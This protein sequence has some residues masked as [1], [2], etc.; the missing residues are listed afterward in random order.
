MRQRRPSSPSASSSVSPPTSPST[1]PR[2]T[3]T[4]IRSRSS[5]DSSEPAVIGGIGKLLRL[6]L[7]A[8]VLALIVPYIHGFLFGST[9]VGIDGG[10][11]AKAG[12]NVSV[13]GPKAVVKGA[14]GVLEQVTEQV[15]MSNL[16]HDDYL[17]STAKHA[18]QVSNASPTAV[19]AKPLPQKQQAQ[20]APRPKP[21]TRRSQHH[22]EE[23]EEYIHPSPPSNSRNLISTLLSMLSAIYDLTLSLLHITSIPFRLLFSL[24]LSL[25]TSIYGYSRLAL[26]HTLR[27][28]VT[29]LAPLTYLVSGILYVFIQTPAR[30]IGAVLTELYPVYIF[31]GA[32]TAVGLAMGLVAAAV[33]Y[34]TAIVFVD[35]VPK[36][37]REQARLVEANKGKHRMRGEREQDEYVF[38]RGKGESECG[39]REST[40][41]SERYQRYTSNPQLSYYPQYSSGGGGYFGSNP[42]GYASSPL[43]SPITPY[44]TGRSGSEARNGSYSSY[45]APTSSLLRAGV[46]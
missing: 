36:Q 3:H 43:V 44:R 24:V 37:Q 11:A 7:Y 15:D 20:K 31:L 18:K 12:T 4:R 38:A 14:K 35:R 34:I 1:S 45:S 28:V 21:P 2:R 32:A 30:L 29:L 26:S 8:A 23:E 39:L 25:I 6:V 33:L 42:Q 17:A 16:K 19:I 27:P 40:P 41:P 22:N 46:A 13:G 9:E 10:N 5:I